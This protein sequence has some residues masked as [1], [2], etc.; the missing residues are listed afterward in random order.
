MDPRSVDYAKARAGLFARGHGRMVPDMDRITRLVE[1]LADPHLAYPTVHVTGTNGKSSTT[2]MVAALLSE[3]GLTAGTFTSPH[4]QTVRERFQVGL[5]P[6]SEQDFARAWAAVEAVAELVDDEV[7]DAEDESGEVGDTVTFFEL[8]TAMALWLFADLPVDIGVIEVGMG[9]RWDATNVVASDIAVITPIDVDHREL[10]DDAVAAAREKAGIIKPGSH[11]VLGA[12]SDEVLAVLLDAAAAV[13]APVLQWGRDVEVVDRAIAV[14]GQLVALRV[15][16]RTIGEVFVPV[17]G[18]H[19]ADNAALALAA[20][21]SLLGPRFDE[22]DDEVVRD[23]FARVT[24]PGRLEVVASEPAVVLDGAHNPHG[25]RAAALAIDEA[26]AFRNV[27]LVIAALADKD[28]HGIVGAW[29]DVVDHV[30]V[31]MPDSPRAAGV[32]QLAAVAEEVFAGTAVAVER[33]DDVAHALEL[34]TGLTG[35]GDGIVVTGSLY[36]VGAA[37]DLYASPA[38]ASPPA[39]APPPSPSEPGAQPP[40]HVPWDPEPDS[41]PPWPE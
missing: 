13:D 2:R 11:V 24:T 39:L 37:R 34:A 32:E 21:A 29:R 36:T 5:Q 12:Q 35:D 3:L 18:A 4:L 40:P 26:F 7:G 28:L 19:Q 17:H 16:E 30:V 1:L 6:V 9:G 41:A 33:A 22:V 23:G 31:T 27:V 10:G 38:P 14:G 15:G 8:T 20:V 25:A